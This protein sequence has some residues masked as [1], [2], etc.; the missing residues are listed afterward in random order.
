[1]DFSGASLNKF[2]SGL[3]E[4][5]AHVADLIEQKIDYMDAAFRNWDQA[6]RKMLK[7]VHVGSLFQVVDHAIEQ[8]WTE[9]RFGEWVESFL[10]DHIPWIV[11][12]ANS[13]RRVQQASSLYLKGLIT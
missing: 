3:D 9:E 2:I 12:M 8:G 6:K 11:R 10:I 13:V 5:P 4:V 1:M 7:K